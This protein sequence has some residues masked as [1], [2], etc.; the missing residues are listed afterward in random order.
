MRH[1]ARAVF[2]LLAFIVAIPASAAFHLWTMNELY[3]NASGSVQFLEVT[4]LTG[5]QQF[6]AGHTLRS[7][8]G[9]TTQTFNIPSDL[10]GDTTGRRMLIA[11]HDF[12]VPNGFF[13]TTGGSLNWG[14][15]SDIWAYGALPSG[16]LS[17][18]RDG[19]TAVNSPRNFAG[20]SGTVGASSGPTATF[21]VQALWWRSPGGSENGWGIN[22]V[23]QGNTLFGTWFTYDTD[24]SDLWL[25]MDNLQ[26]TGTNTYSGSVYRASGSPFGLVPYDTSRFSATP[27]GSATFTFTDAS[28]GSVTWTVS[29]VTQT[30]PITKF[31]YQANVPTCTAGGAQGANVNYQDLWWRTPAGSENGAG[32]NIIHQGDILFVTWFTYDTDGSQMWL[33]MDNAAKTANGVYSGNVLQAHGSP[34]NQV[35]YDATRFG[36]TVVGTGTITFSDASNGTFSYTVKGFTQSKPITRFIYGSP[37]TTCAFTA[38]MGDPGD[39]YGH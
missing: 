25:F 9:G 6:V 36:A 13:S 4:A 26:L 7:T 1:A 11:T 8:I 30:K 24:G 15:G 20:A 21:N 16:N 29:G 17:L 35:P 39:P 2:A 28:N 19:T 27:V 38:S 34:I 23:H 33:F 18:N 3:S 5:G 37:T 31:V 12:V 32:I 10:P 22:I 14:E